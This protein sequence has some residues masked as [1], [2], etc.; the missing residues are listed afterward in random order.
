MD[1]KTAMQAAG[2]LSGPGDRTETAPPTS[3]TK[4]AAR[5]IDVF[6]GETQ[7]L[8]G[9]S[10]EVP[11]R[12]VTALIGPSGSGKSTFL[13]C[14]NRMNEVLPGVRTTGA[15]AL[16][17]EDIYAPGI[18]PVLVRARVGMVFQRPNPFPKSIYE[19]VA[20]GPRIHGLARTREDLDIIVAGSLQ[21]A[22]LWNE[23]ADRLNAQAFSLTEAQQQR[24]VIA[25]ALALNPEIILMDEPSS[26]LDPVATA[27]IEELIDELAAKVC[28]V[29]VTHSMAQAARVSHKTA[30][31]HEGRLVEAASTEEIFTNPRDSRTH[32]FITGRFG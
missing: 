17:G 9:V 26:V 15:L 4:A 23:V 3:R 24:L 2:A 8:F 12:A 10:L 18:D 31:F 30:F 11:D 1:L 22:G 13:R 25:R 14:L 7:A 27:R 6:Y 20:Y 32:D 21:R 28:I 16:D 19:N 5:G 29:I